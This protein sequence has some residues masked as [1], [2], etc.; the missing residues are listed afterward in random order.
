LPDAIDE[1]GFTLKLDQDADVRA[2]GWTGPEP[3]AQQG[4]VS[5]ASGGVNVALI[6][7]PQEGRESLTFLADTYNILR[8]SQPG[9]TF[10]PISDGG[11][12]VDREPGVFGGFK[13]LDSGGATV[14]GGLIGTW[15]CTLPQ[16]AF[17]ITLTGDDAT[18]VQLRFDRVLDNFTCS[19]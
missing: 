5:F 7:G 4:T 6:W 10:D 14:G 13:T 18:L 9:F 1:Y 8:T 19:S 17:R 2:A 11:I 15:V 16:T 12:V 3:N